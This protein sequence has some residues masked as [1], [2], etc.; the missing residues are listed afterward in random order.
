MKKIIL[1]VVALAVGV[2]SL[3]AGAMATSIV[4]T[5][6]FQ[7]HPVGPTRNPDPPVV[8]QPVP[9]DPISFPPGPVRAPYPPTSINPGGPIQH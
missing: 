4:G 5:N 2:S 8:G 3:P 6:A 9:V 1:S 7:F